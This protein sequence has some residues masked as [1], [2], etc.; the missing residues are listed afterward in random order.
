MRY[1]YGPP[2]Q[3]SD[4]H[5]PEAMRRLS[6]DLGFRIVA[7]MPQSLGDQWWFWIEHDGPRPEFPE[8]IRYGEWME[9][10]GS[11]EV[12]APYRPAGHRA[13][14]N[15]ALDAEYGPRH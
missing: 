7:A 11:D 14:L 2:P 8:H 13:A 15:R 3:G 1:Q 10:P 5:A 12:E 9:L 4:E 6:A